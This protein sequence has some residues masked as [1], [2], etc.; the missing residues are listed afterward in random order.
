[1]R[2]VLMPGSDAVHCHSPQYWDKA[3][4]VRESALKNIKETPTTFLECIFYTKTIKKTPT[5]KQKKKILLAKNK[6][7]N[8][9]KI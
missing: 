7:S 9:N 3:L 5:N 2:K 6:N 1:M 8:K 4:N